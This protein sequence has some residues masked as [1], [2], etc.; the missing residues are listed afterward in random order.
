MNLGQAWIPNSEDNVEGYVEWINKSSDK[1]EETFLT[2]N[3]P[4]WV[5]TRRKHEWGMLINLAKET[6]PQWLYSL[7]TTPDSITQS[8]ARTTRRFQDDISKF[9]KLHMGINIGLA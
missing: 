2:S 6:S 4:G 7:L 5:E 3:I 8:P 9:I 1:A